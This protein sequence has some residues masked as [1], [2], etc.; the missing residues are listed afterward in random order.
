MAAI[1]EDTISAEAL[2]PYGLGTTALYDTIKATNCFC[3][4]GVKIH[5]GNN[6]ALDFESLEISYLFIVFLPGSSK[7]HMYKVNPYCVNVFTCMCV[8]TETKVSVLLSK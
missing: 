7:H 1:S 6:S 5:N 8:I 3:A 2:F 4:L